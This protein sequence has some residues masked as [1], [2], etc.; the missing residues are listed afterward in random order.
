[1]PAYGYAPPQGMQG[2]VTQNQNIDPAPQPAD[3][4]KYS[5]TSYEYPQPQSIQI[6]DYLKQYDMQANQAYNDTRLEARSGAQTQTNGGIQGPWPQGT[7]VYILP[8]FGATQPQSPQNAR[9]SQDQNHDQG[10]AR[11][12]QGYLINQAEQLQGMQGFAGKPVARTADHK[13]FEYNNRNFVSEGYQPSTGSSNGTGY[14]MPW[15]GARWGNTMPWNGGRSGFNTPWNNNGKGFSLP[16]PWR[17][18]AGSR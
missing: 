13:T 8:G 1:M 15:N 12:A 2:Q 18:T 5:S 17:A 6:Y 7:Q 9:R 10:Q 14:N 3:T 11:N 16:Q 4:Q